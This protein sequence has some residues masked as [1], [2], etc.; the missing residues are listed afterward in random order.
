MDIQ[1]NFKPLPKEVRQ[2]LDRYKRCCNCHSVL[3]C[4]VTQRMVPATDLIILLDGVKL[5]SA[6]AAGAGA[7][8]GYAVVEVVEDGKLV[9]ETTQSGYQV[10]MELLRGDVQILTPEEYQA[11]LG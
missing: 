11:T 9:T 7:G 8:D 3:T 10:K 4:Q 5:E 1:T 6:V 2:K